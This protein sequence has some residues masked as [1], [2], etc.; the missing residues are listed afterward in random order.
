MLMFCSP[1]PHSAYSCGV[2]SGYCDMCCGGRGCWRELIL[3]H[4]RLDGGQITLT[5]VTSPRPAC[6]RV[7]VVVWGRE[8]EK[9][10][11]S[12]CQINLSKTQLPHCQGRHAVVSCQTWP[13]F[14]IITS[15]SS[16]ECYL[17]ERWAVPGL[18]VVCQKQKWTPV[19]YFWARGTFDFG[20]KESVHFKM[21]TQRAV[22][23]HSS[24]HSWP[25]RHLF[26]YQIVKYGETKQIVFTTF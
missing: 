5:P 7:G 23:T 3:K 26:F 21:L 13:V 11:L 1:C 17:V 2:G 4:R 14:V 15:F 24:L 20:C 25:S 9:G 6:W 22:H 19:F 18:C 10:L 8:G 12:Q 16:M